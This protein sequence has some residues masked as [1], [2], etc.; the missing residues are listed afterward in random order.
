MFSD[1]DISEEILTEEEKERRFG[2]P[3]QPC[4]DYSEV[5]I[6]LHISHPSTCGRFYKCYNGRAY[7]MDCPASEHWS[8]HLDRCDYAPLAKCKLDGNYQYK[9]RSVKPAQANTIANADKT[10]EFSSTTYEEVIDPRCNGGDPFKPLHFQ[11]LADC[12]KFYK[13]YLGK[14]YVIKCPKGQQWASRLNRCDFPSVAKCSVKL[15]PVA[16]SLNIPKVP[17]C[18]GNGEPAHFAIEGHPT[19]FFSCIEKQVFVMECSK[20]EF[21]HANLDRCFS[22]EAPAQ[23]DSPMF[24]NWVPQFPNS[25]EPQEIMPETKDDNVPLKNNDTFNFN[26]GHFDSHC[27]SQDDPMNPTLL[28]NPTD[29][30]RFF[31]CFAGKAFDIA[32]PV[33][34]EYS[35][36]N[37]R[38]DYKVFAQCTL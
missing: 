5:V 28:K 31:K 3:L 38:C 23:P 4:A 30:K 15:Q 20:G 6:P 32:C 13:C 14:A 33:N 35:S 16:A 19:K 21:Y 37:K 7:L 8:V 2:I 34:Q 26:S 27:P 1:E 22:G 25:I 9:K 36:I 12:S 11:H 17:E 29:C 18:P 24:P 10:N